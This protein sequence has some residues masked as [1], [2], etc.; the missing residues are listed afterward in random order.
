MF[1][2]LSEKRKS[3][4]INRWIKRHKSNNGWIITGKS[5]SHHSV[6]SSLSKITQNF[7][8]IKEIELGPYK[9][10]LYQIN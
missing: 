5:Q 7:N 4:Y 3:I 9:A 1:M 8:T 6:N 10:K 2:F